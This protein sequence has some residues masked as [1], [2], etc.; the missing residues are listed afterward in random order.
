[1]PFFRIDHF[2]HSL[3]DDESMYSLVPSIPSVI[4][5][6]VVSSLVTMPWSCS[7]SSS[8]GFFC[9]ACTL[10][11]DWSTFGWFRLRR[12]YG[13]N[14]RTGPEAAANNQQNLAHLLLIC[15]FF[16]CGLKMYN[17][18]GAI[19][20]AISVVNRSWHE[21]LTWIIVTTCSTCT[22]SCMRCY[23]TLIN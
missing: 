2:V 18:I 23:Y 13:V 11:G 3:C 8:F 19:K 16:F 17:L 6:H 12:L 15:C 20:C 14:N 1:M 21:T 7:A 4:D 5:S 22:T 9:L 10:V